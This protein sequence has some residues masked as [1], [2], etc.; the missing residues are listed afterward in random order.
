M[1]QHFCYSYFWISLVV[2]ISATHATIL[3]G[4][5]RKVTAGETIIG[6]VGIELTVRSKMQCSDR[7]VSFNYASYKTFA[8]FMEYLTNFHTTTTNYEF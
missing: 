4:K 1:G 3:P 5:F 2:L 8:Y 6:K 7:F